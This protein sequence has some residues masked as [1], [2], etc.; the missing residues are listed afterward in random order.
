MDDSSL[1]KKERN[2]IIKQNKIIRKYEKY[3]KIKTMLEQYD[4][5]KF[6]YAVAESGVTYY[7]GV[8]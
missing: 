7:I 5:L 8:M 1:F 4:S 3:R 2:R 6:I